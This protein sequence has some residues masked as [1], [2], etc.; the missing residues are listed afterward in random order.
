MVGDAGV[1][2]RGRDRVDDGGVVGLLLV[3]LA[4]GVDQQGDQAAQDGAAQPHGDHVEK[5][6]VWWERETRRES[7]GGGNYL[8]LGITGNVN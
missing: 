6:E 3:A 7:V 5:V 8:S 2:R 1:E 4:V